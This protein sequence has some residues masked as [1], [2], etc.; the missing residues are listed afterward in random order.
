MSP[1]LMGATPEV[2]RVV[3]GLAW[4]AAVGASLG[5]L[6]GMILFAADLPG[7]LSSNLLAPAKRRLLIGLIGSGVGLG[8]L[9]GLVLAFGSYE[10]LDRY[11]ARLG[12]LVLTGFVPP[13]LTTNIW[14]GRELVLLTYLALFVLA[15]AELSL[16][17]ASAPALGSRGL[18][19]ALFEALARRSWLAPALVGVGVVAFATWFS[20]FT[21][22][23]HRA[24][25][26]SGFD[27]GIEENLL[28]NAAH[29]E[30]PLFRTTP[31]GG[32]QTHLGYH[33]TW[34]SYLI[35]PFYRLWPRAE[36][37]LLLQAIGTSLGAVPLFLLARRRLGRWWGV[38]LALLYLVYGPL[39]GS[40]LY[41][42]HYQPLGNVLI[43]STLYCLLER[44]LAGTIV[45]ATLTL[46][47]REDM[48]LLLGVFT[49]AMILMGERPVA[50]FV[51]GLICAIHFGMLKLT[52]MP[53]FLGGQSAYINQ[54]QGLLPVGEQ[55]FDGVIK[56]VLAN[57]A[58]TLSTLLEREKLSYLLELL[59]PFA[60][61]PFRRPIGWLL[62]LPGF[63]FTLLATKYPA[64]LM[65]SFQYT[66]YWTMFLFVGAIW[67]LEAMPSQRRAAW[68]LP[69]LVGGALASL[70]FGAIV[71]NQD[72]RG[73]WDRHR[74]GLS[75][76][77][78]Q[79]YAQVSSLAKQLPMSDS[80]VS[81][82]RLVPHVSNRRDSFT[83]RNG[84]QDATWLFTGNA[85][86]PDERPLIDQ[87][88]RS[89]QYGIVA[90]EGE[91]FIAKKGADPALNRAYL[92]EMGFGP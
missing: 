38:A 52:I 6:V 42:F 50:G 63:F 74:L 46:L 33:Q 14:A 90:R 12:P 83:L 28:W 78:R 20:V 5:L 65:T 19:T 72:V 45:F 89:G 58:F 54:Y 29:L 44:R 43:L 55:S 21:I 70:H 88:L 62:V 92:T 71:K 17:A 13:L 53:R 59:A 84:L 31:L 10:R 87:A 60:L 40:I 75:D 39:H 68:A 61:L 69:L 32:A 22:N 11:A 7:Y 34:I 9:F 56:T 2:T 91:F 27:L 82:E 3:R 73:A 36:F 1:T 26:T 80:V 49:T 76:F 79:R 4:L 66:T 51:V 15:L 37:L 18:A 25:R 48:S 64:L 67:A 8:A 57:P 85:A 77:E 86:A 16:R 30:F 23:N 24:L 47:L 41:D 35:A 81:S